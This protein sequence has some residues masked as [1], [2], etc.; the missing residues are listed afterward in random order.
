MSWMPHVCIQQ[1][2]HHIDADSTSVANLQSMDLK[3]GETQDMLVWAFPKALETCQDTLLGRIASN[4]TPVEFQVACKGA[5]PQVEVA[6]DIPAAA[7]PV[8][9]AAAST[10]EAEAKPAAAAASA[11]KPAAAAGKKA[12]G[13]DAI[14]EQPLTPRS[15]VF[16]A[17][18]LV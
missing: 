1:H 13:K 17:F 6:L 12:T 4:P 7:V 16:Q 11:A 3:F 2:F 18:S 14:P 15:Q 8:D 10:G 5:K 9:A